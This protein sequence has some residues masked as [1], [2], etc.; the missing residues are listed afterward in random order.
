MAQDNRN[1]VAIAVG[2]VVVLIIAGAAFFMYGSGS[3]N[4]QTASSDIPPLPETQTADA[5]VTGVPPLPEGLVEMTLGSPDAPVTMVE[6]AS[7]TCG[8]CRA[9]HL[10]RLPDLKKKY[11]DTGKL[12]LVMRDY[13]LDG[14][15]LRASMMARCAGP[16]RYFAYVETVFEQ[17]LQ[18]LT[19]G[20]PMEGLA[21][22]AKLAG[23]SQDEFDS[24]MSNKELSQKIVQASQEA[25]EQLGIN[26]TPSFYIDGEVFSGTLALEEYERRIDAVLGE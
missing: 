9:F 2:I 4:G 15:A 1:I 22:I 8:H 24:C 20:E 14:F 12:R 13:P 5:P 10:E 18:W 7:L 16:D 17:Q 21:R 11:I 23:M 19:G 6:F 26:A 3:G 25:R